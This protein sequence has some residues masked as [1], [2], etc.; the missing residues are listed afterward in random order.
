MRQ[1]LFRIS[2]LCLWTDPLGRTGSS[3]LRFGTVEQLTPDYT[4]TGYIRVHYSAPTPRASGWLC[5][6]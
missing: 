6:V 1:F 2:Q 5:L 3:C 4:A